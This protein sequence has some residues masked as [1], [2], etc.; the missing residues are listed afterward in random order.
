MLFPSEEQYRTWFERAGFADVALRPVAPDW[1]RDRRAPYAVAVTGTKPAPGASPLALAPP[2]ERVDGPLTPR[3]RAR[4]FGRLVGGSL[5][6]AA[7]IP[8]ALAMTLRARL[9][10]RGA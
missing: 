4:A 6:G 5:A 8:I 2:A 7:F 3:Q 1:Y 9:D 10:R